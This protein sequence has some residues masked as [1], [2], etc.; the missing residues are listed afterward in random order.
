MDHKLTD[1]FYHI[2][3]SLWLYGKEVSPR[4]LPCKEIT[5]FTYTLPP[6][7]RFMCFD[8]RKLKLDYIKQEFLWYLRG[9]PLDISIKF[10]AKMWEGLINDDGTI[11]SNYGYFI[12]NPQ[13]A[14]GKISN[15]HRVVHELIA[16]PDS[17]RAVICILA[18]SYLNSETKD[19]PCT[20]YINF[21]IREDQLNMMV[22]MRSQDAIFG[23]GN[24]APCFSLVH[25]LMWITLTKKYPDLKLGNYFHMSDSFHVYERHYDMI[26]KIVDKPRVSVDFH[27]GCPS[28]NDPSIAHELLNLAN[29]VEDFKTQ[30]ILNKNLPRLLWPFSQW[31]M[32]RDD[33]NTLVGGQHL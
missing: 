16:D 7:A 26:K 10:Q 9:D 18:N 22:R 17:R 12:F 5:N 6:R 23:M 1:H 2:L 15:F 28:M 29:N 30:N 14:D 8:E 19:Y 11:N 33:P 13:G 31:L 20:C 21:H 24:D 4:G 32:T 3:E 25:E 27:E